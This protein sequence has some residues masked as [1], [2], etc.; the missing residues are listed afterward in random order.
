MRRLFPLVI[1]LTTTLVVTESL[2]A[3]RLELHDD[4]HALAGAAAL[5]DV[6]DQ[7]P[8]EPVFWVEY[9]LPWRRWTLR[10]DVGTLVM[11][12]GGW[13]VWAGIRSELVP[14]ALPI[15]W[16]I[17]TN[18]GHYRRG[19]GPLL[20]H[21]LEFRSGFEMYGSLNREWA[22]GLTFHHLSNASVGRRNPGTEIL[23]LV[24]TRSWPR[25]ADRLR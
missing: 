24:V 10:P 19:G 11:T 6:I 23:S 21:R 15:W 2:A 3:G 4:R 16:A 20:G 25:R 5:H 14:K 12:S 17:T 1:L 22:L 18:I 13:Q 7:D 9:R 8:L